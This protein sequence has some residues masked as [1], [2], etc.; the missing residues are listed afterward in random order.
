MEHEDLLRAVVADPD[1]DAPRLSFAR[2]VRSSDPDRARFIELQIEHAS[3]LRARADRSPRTAGTVLGP[4]T[5][6]LER[7][8]EWAG[9]I[10]SYAKSWKFDRGFVMKIAIDP[11]AFLDRGTELFAI[12]PIR[13]IELLPSG[14]PFP[15]RELAGSPLLARLDALDVI[16]TALTVTDVQQ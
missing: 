3:A 2:V 14:K 7:H 1:D 13:V 5:S 11:Y 4:T 12:A 15:A 16:D 6:L 8:P 9:R 10:R